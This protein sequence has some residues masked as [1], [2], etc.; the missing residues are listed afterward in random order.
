MAELS[1]IRSA[2]RNIDV[3]I[4]V[5]VVR[6]NLATGI[7]IPVSSAITA[8]G[9][10]A[11]I[12]SS[13]DLASHALTGILVINSVASLNAQIQA[14]TGAAGL[15]TPI[16]LVPYLIGGGPATIPIFPAAQVPANERVA[17]R[18]VANSTT[19]QPVVKFIFSPRPY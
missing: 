2:L 14:G 3:S 6:P 18:M 15:E 7:T 13:G 9:A 8:F 12:T 11:Q 16:A 17:V 10:W 4:K 19:T 1:A 5:S